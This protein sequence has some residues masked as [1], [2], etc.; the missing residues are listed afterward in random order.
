MLT[1]IQ[2]Y[3]RSIFQSAYALF[4]LRLLIFA[5]SAASISLA[6]SLRSSA[7]SNTSTTRCSREGDVLY[8]LGWPIIA[9]LYSLPFIPL[10]LLGPPM[11]YRSRLFKWALLIIDGYFLAL[12]AIAASVAWLT[13]IDWGCDVNSTP[14]AATHTI[15]SQVVKCGGS[16]SCGQLTRLGAML[17]T[18]TVFWMLAFGVTAAQILRQQPGMIAKSFLVTE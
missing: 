6:R 16:N 10:L 17:T 15:S 11:S 12:Q 14:S 3:S 13:Y 2:Q 5:L 4:V 18:T 9:L 8:L 1:D 7:F